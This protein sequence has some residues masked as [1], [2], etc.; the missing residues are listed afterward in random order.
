M[1]NSEKIT[2]EMKNEMVTNFYIDRAEAT[3]S[4][5]HSTTRLFRQYWEYVGKVTVG[6]ENPEA[7]SSRAAKNW[8]HRFSPLVQTQSSS[9]SL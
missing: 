9:R 4:S 8:A 6:E 1:K 2:L 5:L 3:V 7:Q